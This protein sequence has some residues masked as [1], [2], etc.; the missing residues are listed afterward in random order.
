[1]ANYVRRMHF[2]VENKKKLGKN[3]TYTNNIIHMQDLIYEKKEIQTLFN[4]P[5][6]I[7]YMYIN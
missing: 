7:S 1:M 6:Y 3:D 5:K 2:F 4:L